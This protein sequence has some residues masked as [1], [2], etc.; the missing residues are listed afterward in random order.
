MKKIILLFI[1]L[2][3]L[4]NNLSS[5]H[6]TSNNGTTWHYEKRYAF[7]GNI[8]YFKITIAEDT[9]INSIT[10]KKLVRNSAPACADRTTN[11]EY[12]YEDDSVVYFYDFER[13]EF[14]TLYNFNTLVNNSWEIIITTPMEDNDTITVKVN[15]IGTTTINGFDLKTLNVTYIANYYDNYS[16]DSKIIYG[17]GDTVYMFRLK[18]KLSL[19]CDIDLAD[20]LRCYDD[21]YFGSYSSGI[22]A[23]CT[24]TGIINKAVD[25]TDAE[26]YPMPAND[27]I[28]IKGID[29]SEITSI[30]LSDISG[31]QLKKITTEEISL[32]GILPGIYFIKIQLKNNKE[33]FEKIIVE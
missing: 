9:V 15:S 24:Y 27:F 19:A 6:F 29:Y 16:F 8:D 23:S 28:K 20:G 22:R 10:C 25:R 14:Q 26:L 13:G 18:P 21:T 12:I 11:F 5:Q 1:S 30:E 17:I 3:S 4:V 32:S 33:V 7:S 31:H 2:F